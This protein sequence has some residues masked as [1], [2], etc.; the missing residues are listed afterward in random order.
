MNPPTKFRRNRRGNLSSREIP[1][2]SHDDKMASGR[3]GGAKR[4]DRLPHPFRG[5]EAPNKKKYPLIVADAKVAAN[6]G[7]SAITAVESG[8]RHGPVNH[9]R[10]ISAPVLW[11]PRPGLVE[12]PLRRKNRSLRI[13][14]E[15]GALAPHPE[16]FPDAATGHPLR[17]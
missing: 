17:V 5:M 14:Q 16:P 15:C 2:H 9:R 13:A 12:F 11:Q 6:F 1:V 10:I 7:A 4:V 3:V 8:H